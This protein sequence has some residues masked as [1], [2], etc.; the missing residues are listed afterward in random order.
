[1]E[2]I[3]HKIEYDGKDYIIGEPTLEMWS[4]LISVKD[5]ESEFD[6][7]LRLLQMATG[8]ES[9]E[10]RQASSKSVY[11]AADGL[12]DYYTTQDNKFIESFTF[13]DKKYKFVELGS[14]SFGEFVDIDDQMTKSEVERMKNLHLLMAL[15]YRQIDND[16]NYM[17]Y[18]T[19]RISGT[20][21]EFKQLPIKYLNGALFFFYVIELILQKN[22]QF[23]LTTIQWWKWRTYQLIKI[24]KTPLDG[25][26][27]LS[28]WLKKGYLIFLKWFKSTI[29][30]R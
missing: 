11:G 25:I 18:D 26:Q 21:E 29:L 23:S 30:K 1:M 5:F 7:A 27:S 13:N 8:L 15:L 9:D 4:Q 17:D 6:L 16:G 10:L 24:L 20:A 3:I 2:T 19:K 14:L 22:I 12:I 28:R